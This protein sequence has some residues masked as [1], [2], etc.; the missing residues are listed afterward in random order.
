[1][2]YAWHLHEQI[3]ITQAGAEKSFFSLNCE[4]STYTQINSVFKGQNQGGQYLQKYK[5][6]KLW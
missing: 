6:N 1:M 3:K 5:I 4:K 2:I